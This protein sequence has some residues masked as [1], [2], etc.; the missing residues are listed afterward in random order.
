M[1]GESIKYRA[2]KLRKNMTDAERLL[3]RH[4]RNRE[5]G[6][7]KFRRQRPIGPYIVDFVC[8]EK[9]LVVE[10]DG[11]QHAG[12]VELDTKRSGYLK[13][14]GYRVLR[15]W[16]NEVLKET[17]SALTVILSSLDGNVTSLLPSSPLTPALSPRGEGE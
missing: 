6:G 4:L 16:N 13:E 17:E 15:F 5:L 1:R 9:K 7:Y 3:W 12:Q 14:K 2:K 10:V 11:G 8:I